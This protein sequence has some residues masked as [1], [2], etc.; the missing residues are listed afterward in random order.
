MQTNR[1]IQLGVAV[2]AMAVTGLWLSASLTLVLTGL[3]RENR[4]LLAMECTW[5][6]GA[7]ASIYVLS[8]STARLKRVFGRFAQHLRTPAVFVAIGL[9]AL[10][11]VLRPDVMSTSAGGSLPSVVLLVFTALGLLLCRSGVAQL[12]STGT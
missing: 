3:F 12:E 5:Y 9:P 2:S 1:R 8:L 11:W 10:L 7:I 6:L 4:S